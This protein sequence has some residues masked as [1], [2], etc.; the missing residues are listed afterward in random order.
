MHMIACYMTRD[1]V[2]IVLFANLAE[3]ISCSKRDVSNK[4]FFTIFCNPDQ[5]KLDQEGGVWSFSIGT[6]V[7]S[8]AERPTKV[9]A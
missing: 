4:D 1:D 8:L 6:H 9:P 2:N 5:V 3:Q 7:P